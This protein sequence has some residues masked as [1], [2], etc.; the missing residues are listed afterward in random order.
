MKYDL[1]YYYQMLKMYSSTAEQISKIRW[2]FVK[3]ISPKIVLDYGCGV[4]YFKAYAP[5]DTIIDTF[6]ILPV[7]QTSILHD[8]Y[9]LV[10]FWDVLEHENWGNLERNPDIA[11][12]KVFD[13]TDFVA[14]TVPILPEEKEFLNWKHRKPDEH[15]FYFSIDILKRFF[16]V[17]GFKLIKDGFPESIMRED[18]Y[19]ALYG[20]KNNTSE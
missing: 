6:D 10:T 11:M 5:K 20:K 13:I 7:P 15:K 3:S 17:R 16:S 2:E 19:S 18:I 1:N 9:N 14:I 8:H 12:D 4:G